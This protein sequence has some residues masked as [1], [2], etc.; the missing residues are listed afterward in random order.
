MPDDAQT[1]ADVQRLLARGAAVLIVLGFLTGGLAPQA[2]TGAIHADPKVLLVAHTNALMGG[3][4]MLGAG[5]TMPMVH[6][7]RKGKRRVAVLFALSNYANW[8]LTGIKSFLHVSG[9]DRTGQGAND[10]IFVALFLLVVLPS[11]A[12][13][14][15]WLV[16][17]FR[18][19]PRRSD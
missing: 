13:S 14:I 2:M 15:E 1:L 16:G 5:W 17:L 4:L 11:F 3:L 12:A 8:L 9:V 6:L 10:V 7:A 19:G 18:A